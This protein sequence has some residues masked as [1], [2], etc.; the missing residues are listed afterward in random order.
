MFIQKLFNLDI[1][2]I[3]EDLLPKLIEELSTVFIQDPG[4]IETEAQ[5][6]SERTNIPKSQII[7]FINS[8]ID[9]LGDAEID[10]VAFRYDEYKILKSGGGNKNNELFYAE[11]KVS[12]FK[13]KILKDLI[14][15]VSIAHRLTETSA[16]VG[17]NRLV[18]GEIPLLSKESDLDELKSKL[19]RNPN[20]NWL[21]AFQSRIEGIFI[22]FNSKKLMN[23]QILV[24]LSKELKNYKKIII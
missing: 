6:Q 22:D 17:F 18:S 8:E 3:K 7:S 4:M 14:K 21:P 16:F 10:E 15:N 1:Y 2:T 23:G 5:I 19:S 13:N 11:K 24:V 12:P 9:N 20:I